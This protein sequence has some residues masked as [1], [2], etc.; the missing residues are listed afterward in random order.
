MLLV[1]GA[2]IVDES[3]EVAVESVLVVL[4]LLLHAAN[5]PIAKTIKSFFICLCF[6]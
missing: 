4:E 2:I 3:V 1:S 6:L 5:A